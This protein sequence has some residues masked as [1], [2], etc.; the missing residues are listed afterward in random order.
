[1]KPT[2]KL[3][4]MLTHHD[5]TVP[6]AAAVFAQC[7]DTRARYWGFKEEGLPPAEM[8]ALFAA[9]KSCGKTT[10]LE[11]VAYTE[12]ECLRGAALAAACGCDLLMGTVYSD[13][14]ND[15]C[16]AHGLRYMPFVGQVTGRPSV[17]RGT[18]EGM[19][20]EARR[21]LAKGVYG[22]DLLGYRYTGDA[23]ALNRAFAAAVPAP[24]CLAGSVNSPAR[25]DE[26]KA[27]G[28]AYFTIG[29]AF[30]E[31]AFG[32]SI[33]DQINAVCDYMEGPYA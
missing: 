15:Y 32:A 14:V 9:M 1:M 10:C 3:I 24:I 6:D 4:V 7:R 12:P 30:F 17:L 5:V 11:V 13:A 16:R 20:D 29:S 27:A 21:Y 25:L 31:H 19:I 2:P 8:Q 26:V 18:P 28:A 33:A 22:I 23:A